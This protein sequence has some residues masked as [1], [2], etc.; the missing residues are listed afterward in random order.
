[1]SRDGWRLGHRRPVVQQVAEDAFRH[2]PD[3]GVIEPVGGEFTALAHDLESNGVI[4]LGMEEK[5]EWDP[6]RRR[7]LGVEPKLRPAVE[8]EDV[9]ADGDRWE[10][11]GAR[12][13]VIEAAQQEFGAKHE[14]HFFGGFADGGSHQVGL[15][16]ILPAAWKRHVPGP[17]V[18]GPIG[19][20]DQ[21]NRVRIGTEDDRDGGP[22]QRIA[23]LVHPSAV[24]GKATA[25]P[26]EPGSQW[27]CVWQ[28]PPQH[29]PPGGGPSRLRSVPSLPNESG[30]FR[31][32]AGRAVSDMSR[33]SLRPLHAGQA[34]LVSDRTSWSNSA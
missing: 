18:P 3:H 32:A 25:K 26:G 30:C 31:P 6:A 24:N 20:A 23:P 2:P 29:P 19:A 17:G 14:T 22:D 28:P 27:P 12:D 9:G 10:G 16:R 8:R 11:R 1:M 34:T 33:S 7:D 4:G 13:H 15:R 21:E 5:V